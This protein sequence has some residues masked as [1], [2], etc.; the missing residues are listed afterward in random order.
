VT[1]LSPLAL[2]LAICMTEVARPSLVS[3]NIDADVDNIVLMAMRKES[4][5]RY[6]SAD[7][8]AADIRRYLN[9]EPVVA[10][11]NSFLYRAWKFARRNVREVA[12]GTVVAA[13][14]I[15]ATV[16]SGVQYRRA[17]AERLVAV[18]ERSRAE[19]QSRQAEVARQS[20]EASRRL[21]DGQRDEAQTQRARAEQRVTDLVDLANRTLF[22]VHS[23][24]ESLPGAV[25][26]RRKIVNPTVAY[27]E[28]LEKSAGS[29]GRVRLALGTAYYKVAMI[30]GDVYLPSLQDYDGAHASLAKA[31][32]LL[33]PLYLASPNDPTLMLRWIEIE[34]AQ[35]DLIYRSG[36]REAAAAAHA[37][38][39]PIAIRLGQLRPGDVDSAK[40]EV[41][42]HWRLAVTTHYFDQ[43]AAL[44]HA[45]RQMA[46]MRDLIVRFPHETNLKQE[47]GE[48]LATAAGTMVFSGELERAAESY[49]Q[50]SQLRED[51]AAS[52]PNNVS[53]Q[54]G[55]IVTYGNYATLLGV[56]WSPNLG[57]FAEA[58]AAAG[59]AVAIAR[60][61]VAADPQDATARFNLSM[62]LSRLGAIDPEPGGEAESL[63]ILK[64]AIGLLEPVAKAN[65][66]SANIGVQL[67]TLREYAGHRLEALDRNAEAVAEYQ[68]SLAVLEPFLSTGNASVA[69][70]AIAD[71]EALA[72]LYAS[73]GDR[74]WSM[75]FARRAV[76]GSER[77]AATQPSETNAG[78]LAHSYFVLASVH[79]KFGDAAE[80][81]RVAKQAMELWRPIR[82]PGVLGMHRKEMEEASALADQ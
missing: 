33:K 38:L 16:I 44:D 82:N 4:A 69:V 48:G 57:R 62:I 49:R 1:A 21:A 55:L 9:G 70:Q 45:N 29:D 68:G 78:H 43:A 36:R 7:Q 20:E 79:A 66:K 18:H 53:I 35:A 17:E 6:P 41:L 47:F 51:L 11:Q 15:A 60:R 54:Q 74:A 27:L 19:E 72:Q 75:E 5:R 76:S 65:P 13:S 30:Q 2:D 32:A 26:A 37:K 50:S 59:K 61:M 73:L 81:R 25:A 10:R 67:A 28:R 39:L 77:H 56:P 71:H 64:E 58:R 12:A 42:L 80:A 14:L 22:D 34:N 31:E 24:I 3:R 52:D 8:M 40:Q 23:S 46:L 63:A